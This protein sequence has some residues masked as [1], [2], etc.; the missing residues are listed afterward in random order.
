MTTFL[1][2]LNYSVVAP[3]VVA[4]KSR[5]VGLVA[6]LV[7]S[8]LYL[9]ITIILLFISVGGLCQNQFNLEINNLI[10]LPP[11]VGFENNSKLIGLFL[12]YITVS[13]VFFFLSDIMFALEMYFIPIVSGFISGLTPVVVFTYYKG[14]NWIYQIFLGSTV[15]IICLLG[16]IFNNLWN[17]LQWRPWLVARFNIYDVIKSAGWVYCGNFVA[18]VSNYLTLHH[19]S[20]A[21]T[22]FLS[23][24][25]YSRA[26]ASPPKTL[27][28]DQISMFFGVRAN[29]L[30]AN[31]ES[32]QL[33][34]LFTKVTM[35]FSLV[36]WPVCII[37]LFYYSIIVAWFID[38]GKLSVW[39]SREFN[40]LL[41]VQILALNFVFIDSIVSR[42]FIASSRLSVGFL[43]QIVFY[44]ITVL[45]QVY[46][47]KHYGLIG[48]AAS[49][50]LPYA[51][52][53]LGIFSVIVPSVAPFIKYRQDLFRMLK[54]GCYYISPV[55]LLKWISCCTELPESIELMLS[56][57]A[58]FL[59]FI[60]ITSQKQVQEIIGL[61]INFGNR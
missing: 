12:I 27:L 37:V 5:S 49:L 58:L 41:I 24:A 3:L 61:K 13:V 20:I 2:A 47:I 31:S 52:L 36:F 35:G 30:I 26:I 10:S 23:L 16:A 38:G 56:V 22:G 53:V 32:L 8:L 55:L 29:K 11:G 45:V 14:E 6:G 18:L 19:L 7:N 9:N 34:H 60:L 43:S 59:V 46:G 54:V 44:G 40:L 15:V 57:C 39:R 50:V 25:N 4:Q 28:L 21:G 17:Q 42:I 1:R 48:Y 33:A 51:V